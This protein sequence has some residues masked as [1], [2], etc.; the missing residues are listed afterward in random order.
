MVT[1]LRR[2]ESLLGGRLDEIDYDSIAE[3]PGTVRCPYR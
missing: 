2:L 1:R 3:R